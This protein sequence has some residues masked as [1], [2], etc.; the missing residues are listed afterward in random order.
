MLDPPS[1]TF[2]DPAC[3]CRGTAGPDSLQADTCVA[4][5]PGAADA[6][7]GDVAPLPRRLGHCSQ[8][9]RAFTSLNTSALSSK[10]MPG[11]WGGVK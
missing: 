5:G 9:G 7:P 2:E 8:N 10:S 11:S 1:A 3:R 4:K 6:T